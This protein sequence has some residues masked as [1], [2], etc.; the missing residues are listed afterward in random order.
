M[1]CELGFAD[2]VER[3][4]AGARRADLAAAIPLELA[5]Q[6]AALGTPDQVA[7]RIRAYLDA[8]AD[9][10]AVIPCDRRR[11]RRPHRPRLRR[12]HRPHHLDRSGDR[13]MTTVNTQCRLAARPTEKLDAEQLEDR[14]RTQT[15]CRRRTIRRPGRL[16]V[17]RPGDAHLDERR[18]QLCAAGRDRRGDAGAGRRPRRR[19]PASRLRGRR[20]RVRDI[21][22]PALR[23]VRRHRGQQARHHAGAGAGVSQRPRYQRSDRVLRP[24]RCRKART[25]PDRAGL[26][27]GR[28]GGQHRRADRPDQ[29]VPRGR[30]RRWRGQSAAGLS[31]KSDSTPRSTTRAP[32]C[33]KSSRPTPRTVSTSISTMS[34][35]R[36][37]R[38]H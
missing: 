11:P 23:G 32:T 18:P 9:T 5:E 6:L 3:A 22:R 37:W 35:G 28:L 24:A 27:G 14:R 36:R 15:R 17:D 34:A 20:R 26:R 12:R 33:A 13:H 29:G 31:R 19:I 10:V 16:P 8:G 30:H 38:P 7:D 4:R 25:G 2:L 21:R 1:F